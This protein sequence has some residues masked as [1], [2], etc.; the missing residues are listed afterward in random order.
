MDFWNTVGNSGK[1]SLVSAKIHWNRFEKLSEIQL[2]IILRNDKNS[3]LKC[4]VAKNRIPA[5]MIFKE[6]VEINNLK[7]SNGIFH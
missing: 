2:T 6:L 7:Y 3:V 5:E 4:T 1:L